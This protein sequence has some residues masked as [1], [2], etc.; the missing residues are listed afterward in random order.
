MK[1]PARQDNPQPTGTAKVISLVRPVATIAKNDDA[2]SVVTTD[3]RSNHFANA[4]GPRWGHNVRR[5]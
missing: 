2:G 3:P 1:K 4:N 5:K